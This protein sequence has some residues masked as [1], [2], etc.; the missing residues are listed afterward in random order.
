MRM[1]GAVF[2]IES[3]PSTYQC[4]DS[5]SCPDNVFHNKRN[6]SVLAL[7]VDHCH[8][9]GKFRGWLCRNCNMGL[10][11][12][13]DTEESV[14]AMLNYLKKAKDLPTD[15]VLSVSQ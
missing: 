10:G 12:I 1:C 11:Q 5:Y 2:L 8:V 14:L 15:L 7:C 4:Y 9:T 13:G 3:A 6:L